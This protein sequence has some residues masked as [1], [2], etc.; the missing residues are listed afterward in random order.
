MPTPLDLSPCVQHS[1]QNDPMGRESRLASAY[2][3]LHLLQQRIALATY[4]PAHTM[5]YPTRGHPITHKS[6]RRK[7]TECPLYKMV[8]VCGPTH[9]SCSARWQ[10]PFLIGAAHCIA[11]L[12]ELRIAMQPRLCPSLTAPSGATSKEVYENEI[13]WP[14]ST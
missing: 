11:R 3:L 1:P 10:L 8:R 14:E 6:D 5:K 13:P 12:V 9:T 4:R 7:P 2:R